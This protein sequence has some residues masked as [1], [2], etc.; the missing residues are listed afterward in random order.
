MT[1]KT[2]IQ[3]AVEMF[4]NSTSKLATA[5]GCGVLRQHV[6]HWLKVGRVSV[7][8]CGEVSAATGIPCEQLNEKANWKLL[9]VQLTK[10]ARRTAKA[11][12]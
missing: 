3:R 6:E 1:E 7:E 2:G 4:D 10:P 5:V 11:G 12:A 8:R 9:R